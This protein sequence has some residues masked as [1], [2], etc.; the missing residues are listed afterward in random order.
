MLPH[1]L[2]QL[3]L[4]IALL[5]LTACSGTDSD[6]PRTDKRAGKPVLVEVW[7]AERSILYD[8]VESVGT[9][10]GNES[11]TI[12]AKVTDQVAEIHFNDGDL[13]KKGQLLLE[14]TRAEQA[15]EQQEAR[16]NLADAKLQLKRLEKLAGTLSAESQLDEARARVEASQAKLEVMAVR[17]NDRQI[18]APFDGILGFRQVSQGALV[19]PGTVITELDDISQLKLEFAVP[20]VFLA[21][22]NVGAK[23]RSGHVAFPSVVFEG[24]IA[25]IGSRIDPATRSFKAQAVLDNSDLRLRPGML[26]HVNLI[27]AERSAMVVPEEA[28]VQKSGRSLIYVVDSKTIAQALPVTIG[29]RVA[30]GAEILSELEAGTQVVTRGQFTVRDR[31]LVKVVNSTSIAK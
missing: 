21:K 9:L 30:G 3:T 6:A 13:V 27:L 4:G 18:R 15:A 23:V 17:M 16:V 22:V 7:Q 31:Q 5:S 11:V 20:E 8:R 19:R 1:T 25:S 28:I 24:E 2:K 14:L 29:K 12:T 10:K 26:M